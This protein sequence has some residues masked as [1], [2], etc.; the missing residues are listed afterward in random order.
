MFKIAISGGTDENDDSKASKEQYRWS[1]AESLKG[2]ESRCYFKG[3]TLCFDIP[4]DFW[5]AG[6]GFF[7]SPWRGMEGYREY[8][9]EK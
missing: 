8:P 7:A 6:K 1:D 4:C 9:E 2:G 5:I 3:K